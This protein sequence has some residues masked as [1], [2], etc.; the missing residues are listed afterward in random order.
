MSSISSAAEVVISQRSQSERAQRARNYLRE[1]MAESFAPE[2]LEEQR[3]EEI[4]EKLFELE[5][6]G[7]RRIKG[8]T[9]CQSI[10]VISFAMSDGS[11]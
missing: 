10:D 2:L 7:P 5:L 6:G 9:Y 1:S 4:I 3:Q 11:I 8:M